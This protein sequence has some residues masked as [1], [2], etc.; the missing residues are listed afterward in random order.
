MLTVQGFLFA[1]LGLSLNIRAN[2]LEYLII[3]FLLLVALI[4]IL[5]SV[6]SWLRSAIQDGVYDHLERQMDEIRDGIDFVWLPKLPALRYAGA[7]RP[8]RLLI[9]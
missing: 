3:S 8:R 5:V 4:G 7:R 2:D 6:N 9:A 1:A